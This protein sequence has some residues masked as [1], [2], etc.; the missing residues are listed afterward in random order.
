MGYFTYR[1]ARKAATRSRQTR[2]LLWAE[3]RQGDGSGYQDSD[4]V[5]E[6][7]AKVVIALVRFFF[8]VVGPYGLAGRVFVAIALL[9]FWP[10]LV[11]GLEWLVVM[12]AIVPNL[13][14][15]FR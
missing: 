11:S 3:A 14:R 10:A 4:Q 7:V 15:L 6:D 12:W 5:G 2:D 9:W 8:G 13:I 1:N